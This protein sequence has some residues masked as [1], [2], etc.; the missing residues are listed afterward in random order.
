MKVLVDPVAAQ[1]V[2]QQ[3]EVGGCQCVQA[4]NAVRVLTAVSLGLCSPEHTLQSADSL[5][6]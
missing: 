1:R 2:V 3:V 5:P 6:V 4:S